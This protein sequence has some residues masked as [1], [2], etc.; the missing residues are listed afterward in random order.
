MSNLKLLKVLNPILAIV[1]IC[2]AIAII[3]LKYP[4]IPALQGNE[5]IYIIHEIAGKVFIIL[6]VLHII[7]NWNWVKSQI[8]GIKPAKKQGK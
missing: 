2:T 1:F 5:T 3:L 6:A 7:L 8:F 4:V